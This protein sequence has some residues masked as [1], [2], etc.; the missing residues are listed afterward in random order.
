[1][2]ARCI[3]EHS[4]SAWRPIF[5]L[6][7]FDQEYDLLKT[8]TQS[9]NKMSCCENVCCD[10]FFLLFNSNVQLLCSIHLVHS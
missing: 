6:P 1:M 3:H 8:V 7:R 4:E 2:K 5:A 9:C 10:K